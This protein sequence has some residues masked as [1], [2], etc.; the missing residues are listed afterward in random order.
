MAVPIAVPRRMP[1][2]PFLNFAFAPVSDGQGVEVVPCAACGQAGAVR[3]VA[4][5]AAARTDLV[6]TAGS[7]KQYVTY[8]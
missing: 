8:N 4:S 1:P 6:M 2:S 3:A 5:A 7:H